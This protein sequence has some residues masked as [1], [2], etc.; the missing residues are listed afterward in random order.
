MEINA[1]ISRLEEIQM[2]IQ[3]LLDEA[4]VILQQDDY[5]EMTYERAKH[6]WIAH[7]EGALSKDNEWVGGSLINMDDTLLELKNRGRK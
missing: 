2:E 4:K 6:Y 5:G 3:K 7:I 1:M